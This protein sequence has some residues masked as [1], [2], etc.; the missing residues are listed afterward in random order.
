MTNQAKTAKN[1]KLAIANL[2]IRGIERQVFLLNSLKPGDEQVSGV[3]AK[4]SS[5]ME[6]LEDIIKYWKSEKTLRQRAEAAARRQ[7]SAE[8]FNCQSLPE[9]LR[10]AA[11]CIFL[12]HVHESDSEDARTIRSALRALSK[13]GRI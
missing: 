13:Y 7:M 2:I 11:M 5:L 1:G 6:E 9:A 12:S 10:H 8:A 4:V 3:M